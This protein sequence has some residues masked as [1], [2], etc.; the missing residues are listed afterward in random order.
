MANWS[1]PIRDYKQLLGIK[2]ENPLMD[3]LD[4]R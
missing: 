4:L 1:N 2:G 3:L